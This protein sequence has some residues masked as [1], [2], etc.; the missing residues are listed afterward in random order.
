[1][2]M[3]GDTKVVDYLNR[4]LAAELSAMDQYFIHSRMY[5]DWGYHK[6]FERIDH[7]MDDEKEHAN[8]LI[9]RIL[10]LGGQPNLVKREPLRI[11]SKVP[12]MLKNDLELEMQVI[13][14]LKEAI[15]Y[16]ESVRDFTSS[17]ILIQLLKDSEEDHTLWLE[18][19]LGHI[20]SLGLQNYLQTCI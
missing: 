1:M 13:A 2:G 14:L 8:L 5:Q 6:L 7:E 12:E 11:G 3:R 19:Q 18:Q 4:L 15:E 17:H 9:Q 16:C 20:T 10:F